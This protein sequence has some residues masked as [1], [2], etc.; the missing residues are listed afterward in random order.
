MTDLRRAAR[1]DLAW[2]PQ[3]FIPRAELET[4]LERVFGALRPGGGL[5]VPTNAPPECADQ[6]EQAV[7]VHAGHVLGGGPI[8]VAEARAL[9]AEAGY[10]DVRDHDYGGQ[11]VMTA[12][13]P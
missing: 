9:L 4:G 6:M 3:V 7:M 2:V 13:R 5:V 12:V 11:V 8:D 1:F 10:V